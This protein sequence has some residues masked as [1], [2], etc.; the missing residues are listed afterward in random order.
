MLL[1]L[2]FL[3]MGHTKFTRIYW[4]CSNISLEV[5]F[6]KVFRLAVI[7]Y[8]GSGVACKLFRWFSRENIIAQVQACILF[9]VNLY[10]K[11]FDIFHTSWTLVED[12]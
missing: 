11:H 12:R 2:K 10:V 3:T 5:L 9:N 6:L 4:I 1:Q 7:P 8:S